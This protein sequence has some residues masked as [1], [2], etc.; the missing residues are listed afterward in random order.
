MSDTAFTVQ[1]LRD[2]PPTWFDVCKQ[3]SAKEA[4]DRAG[5]PLTQHG[6]RYLAKCFLHDDHHA[7]LSFYDDG[8]YYCFSCKA[9]GDAVKLYEL[10]YNLS[11]NDAAKRLLADFG[12]AEPT[13]CSPT[14][15][16]PT[17]GETPPRAPTAGDVQDAAET[18]RQRRIDELL[19]I[20]R[21]VDSEISLMEQ[22]KVFGDAEQAKLYVITAAKS[23]AKDLISRLEMFSPADL[24]QW[25]AEGASIDAI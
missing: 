8:R 17:A 11:P 18:I 15:C 5:I 20:I 22:K 25:I 14:S 10:Y 4:A 6:K 1:F 13:P 2:K 9:S 21:R 7:S 23:A 3:I 24:V 12:L 16:A 19:S